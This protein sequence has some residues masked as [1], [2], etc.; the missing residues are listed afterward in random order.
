MY[1]KSVQP[2]WLSSVKEHCGFQA[3]KYDKLPKNSS[4]SWKIGLKVLDYEQLQNQ[5][6]SEDVMSEHTPFDMSCFGLDPNFSLSK[7]KSQNP[8][9]IP[10]NVLLNTIYEE[11]KIKFSEEIAKEFDK[12]IRENDFDL[13][14]IRDDIENLE[15]S[16]LISEMAEIFDWEND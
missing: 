9:L 3:F 2:Q 15:D 14:S 4:I 7:Q 16:F 8:M 12:Y 6:Q 13:D 5:Q 11:I 10:F 1:R